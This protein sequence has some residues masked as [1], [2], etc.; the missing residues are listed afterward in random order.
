MKEFFS[1]VISA[2]DNHS[3]GFSA[4]KL[5]AFTIIVMVVICHIKWFK[6][7][8]WEYLGEVLALDFGFICV[9]LGMTTYES[10][11][12]KDVTPPAEQ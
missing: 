8:H 9:C 12:K 11:K 6:S 1:K 5:S 4:R 2:F 7:D 10:I 3:K